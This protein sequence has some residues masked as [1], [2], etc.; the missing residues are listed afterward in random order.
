MFRSSPT[1]DRPVIGMH[2]KWVDPLGHRHRVIERAQTVLNC[3]DFR[4]GQPGSVGV[5]AAHRAEEAGDR[6]SVTIFGT[7]QNIDRDVWNDSANLGAFLP[8]DA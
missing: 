7:A 6:H 8:Q 2:P 3:S 4:F 5:N 1:A